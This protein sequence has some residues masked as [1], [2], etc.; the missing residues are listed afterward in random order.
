MSG[1]VTD[2]DSDRKV[3]TLQHRNHRVSKHQKLIGLLGAGRWTLEYFLVAAPGQEPLLDQRLDGLA[4]HVVDVLVLP[5][6]TQLFLHE[7][8][9]H[10]QEPLQLGMLELTTLYET[11][12][13]R[14]RHGE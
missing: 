5:L 12:G 2:Q 7:R 13:D 11:A 6:Q 9:D 14:G 3:E 4:R 10:A 8:I 1:S